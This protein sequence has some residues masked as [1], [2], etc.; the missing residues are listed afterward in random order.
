M[1]KYLV[2]VTQENIVFRKVKKGGRPMAIVNNRLYRLDDKISWS[3]SASDTSLVVY[4]LDQQQPYGDGSY[5][6][7]EFTKVMIDS[8]KLGKG[9]VSMLSDFSMDKAVPLIMVAVIAWAIISQMMGS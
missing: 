8:L 6:D 7:P 4:D 2:T 9:K 3:D 5:L 1:T